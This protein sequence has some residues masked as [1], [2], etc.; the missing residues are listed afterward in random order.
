[1]IATPDPVVTPDPA[2]TTS[3]SEISRAFINAAKRVKPSVVHINVGTR[4]ANGSGVIVSPDG[5]ILT[6]FHVVEGARKSVQ[7]VRY[8][9]FGLRFLDLCVNLRSVAF[10]RWAYL[11]Q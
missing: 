11:S 9:I 5:Y 1:M 10:F 6:N 3:P 2:Q 7:S 4:G 8:S